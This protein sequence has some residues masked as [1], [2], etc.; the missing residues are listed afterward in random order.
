MSTTSVFEDEVNVCAYKYDG[1]LHRRW[2]AQLAKRE[3]SLIVLNARFAE[4][5]QHPLLGT[6]E[7]GTLSV[8]YYWLD[9]WYNIF[10]FLQ[11]SGELRNF[12]CNINVPPVFH[13]SLLSYID[14]DMD[15]LVE[16]NLSY[17]ILDEDEFIANADLFKY[18][19]E[20]QRRSLEAL[21]QLIRLIESRHFPFNNFR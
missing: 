13:R 17:T 20:L 14:L 4:E 21:Q 19:V 9:C 7:C 5:I 16:P 1:T 6:I 12:Y 2:R 8:E 3:N 15:I 18:P 11:P 10:R